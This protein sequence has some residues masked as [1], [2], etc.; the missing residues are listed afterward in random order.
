MHLD[1][2]FGCQPPMSTNG[3]DVSVEDSDSD[4]NDDT[5]VDDTSMKKKKTPYL[6][7]F[8]M[9]CYQNVQFKQ[10][11]EIS[12]GSQIIS[13]AASVSADTSRTIEVDVINQLII[14]PPT[15]NQ[16]SSNTTTTVTAITTDVTSNTLPAVATTVSSLASVS[17][18]NSKTAFALVELSTTASSDLPSEVVSSTANSNSRQ[19]TVTTSSISTSL[20]SDNTDGPV[21]ASND[22]VSTG[23][24][25]GEISKSNSKVD[26]SVIEV[27]GINPVYQPWT[28][29]K[30][31][32]SEP[33]V[34]T[35]SKE[36]PNAGTKVVSAYDLMEPILKPSTHNSSVFFSAPSSVVDNQNSESVQPS[37]P[38]PQYYEN[39]VPTGNGKFTVTPPSSCDSKDSLNF[40]LESSPQE[41]QASLNRSNSTGSLVPHPTVQHHATF[42]SPANNRKDLKHSVSLSATPQVVIH[43]PSDEN[44]SKSMTDGTSSNSKIQV[45][46]STAISRGT[47]KKKITLF[48]NNTLPLG[49]KSLAEMGIIEGEDSDNGFVV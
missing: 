4:G 27:G 35:P 19:S 33:A 8:P 26:S 29:K 45:R 31:N 9:S 46:G 13:G 30:R 3:V 39:V 20:S 25:L 44:Y 17:E 24:I 42:H 2:K 48:E 18:A 23:K 16:S 36:V 7:F 1:T 22:P 6:N 32:V 40:P 49:S 34:V 12:T 21:S 38:L 11:K 10:P 15:D 41:Q 47:V 5:L 28:V 37:A 14:S 43:Q